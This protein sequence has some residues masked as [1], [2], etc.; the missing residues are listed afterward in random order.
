MMDDLRD[1]R[2]YKNDM[3]HPDSIAVD[4][5]W[6][7]FKNILIDKNA[8]QTMKQVE[9]IRKALNHKSFNPESAAHINHLMQ[10]Q[11][12]ILELQQIYPWMKFNK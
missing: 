10:T 11:Q 4:Y 7:K 1:Y 6:E 5:I 2:F 9:K 3:L 8:L 12:K